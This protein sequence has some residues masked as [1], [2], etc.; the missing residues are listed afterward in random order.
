MVVMLVVIF[1][2]AMIMAKDRIEG[3]A[4]SPGL[5]WSAPC[6]T[7]CSAVQCKAAACAAAN[8][9]CGAT[10]QRS[11]S[12]ERSPPLTP[13][14]VG[15]SPALLA[16]TLGFNL[17]PLQVKAFLRVPCW[18]AGGAVCGVRGRGEGDWG[19]VRVNEERRRMRIL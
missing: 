9:R 4:E 12:W 16:P 7:L 3:V 6:T 1:K 18:L 13:V 19:G 5:S 10:V 15:A 11:G 14:V 8:F 17:L 2:S